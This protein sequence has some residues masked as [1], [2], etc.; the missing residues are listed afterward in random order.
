MK[1]IFSRFL[2]TIVIVILALTVMLGTDKNRTIVQA[3][4]GSVWTITQTDAQKTS[5]AI[6]WSAAE[7]A[8]SYNVY[9]APYENN[10][11]FQ[12]VKN[13]TE[14]NIKITGLKPGT[15]YSVRLIPCQGEV[16]GRITNG[17]VVTLPDKL[18]GLKEYE[19]WASFKKIVITWDQLSGADGYEAVLYNS[20]GKKIDQTTA[21]N[22]ITTFYGVKDKFCKVKVR[23]YVTFNKKKYYS[24]W[25][26]IYCVQ[27]PKVKKCK[28]SGKKLNVSWN[29]VT[30]ATGY[31]VYVSTT[32]GKNF[33][34]VTTLG[35]NA[36]SYSLSKFKGK[37]ISSKK[38][39]YVY[40]E[41]V[42]N[43]G[44]T[45]ND[46]GALFYWNSKNKNYEIVDE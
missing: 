32:D 42:C 1:R 34:K 17:I 11:E 15:K 30:G 46:S 40:V 3:G 27:Q 9:I 45:K 39:Y 33:K 21:T 26:T 5:I 37:K 22:S 38:T 36:T 24:A 6:K 14:T 43:K 10:N 2:G 7:R 19:W 28:V 25:K 8:T 29:K 35:K 20:K 13:T 44:K 41:A 4:M 18:Y 31:K 23:A 16:T 12:F